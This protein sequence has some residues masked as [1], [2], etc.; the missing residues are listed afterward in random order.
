M[1]RTNYAL[2]SQRGAALLSVLV[3]SII[4]S[5]LLAGAS[6]L[7]Q[8]RLSL[9]DL[10]TSQ[11]NE[12]A[13]ITAKVNELTYLAST[14]RITRAG[15]SQGNNKEA[16]QKLDG[17]W[18]AYLTG[19]E[20]RA[21]GHIYKEENVNGQDLTLRY[22]LQAENGLIPVNTSDQFWVRKWLTANGADT[23][24]VSILAS[25]LADY[26][27][28]DEWSR[29]A[30]AEARQYQREDLP[31]PPNYLLQ[32]CSELH[33]VLGW[34]ELLDEN[35]DM[36][37]ECSLLRSSDVNVNAIPIELWRK[38]WPS[39]ADKIKRMRDNN[40]WLLN[41]NDVLGVIPSVN[42]IPEPYFGLITYRGLYIE[43]AGPTVTESVKVV[44]QKGELPPFR[45]FK[46]R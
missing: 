9:A 40:Q 45:R 39:S 18:T 24:D 41:Y 31:V 26:A 37:A 46:D 16:L 20:I 4:L 6:E 25:R 19:D 1:M 28:A 11:L 29:P 15:V 35:D 8:R 33:Q 17:Q 22:S 30:G 14:Q 5:L 13:A 42:G 7:M 23:S 43:V 38:L 32:S 44:V 3:V 2:T 21:D 34:K 27:D 12:K 10:S 36:T